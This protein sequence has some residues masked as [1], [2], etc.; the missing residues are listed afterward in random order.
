MNMV[1]PFDFRCE[2]VPSL[3]SLSNHKSQNKLPRP[4]SQTQP[5]QSKWVFASLFC[6]QPF[7][8]LEYYLSSMSRRVWLIIVFWLCAAEVHCRRKPYSRR[9]TGRSRMGR[10]RMP[11][12]ARRPKVA[13]PQKLKIFEYKDVTSGATFSA[14][15][16][17]GF[18]NATGTA[19]AEYFACPENDYLCSFLKRPQPTA[20]SNQDAQ[21]SNGG[22]FAV[23]SNR[24]SGGDVAVASG[25]ARVAVSNRIAKTDN[26]VVNYRRELYR[27]PYEKP[28]SQYRPYKPYPYYS[29]QS[30]YPYHKPKFLTKKIIIVKPPVDPPMESPPGPNP[31]GPG[32]G[33][34]PPNGVM[35]P[36]PPI[37]M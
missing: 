28:R 18:A 35:F 2:T 11:G 37:Y 1:F 10:S 36:P 31:G 12:V 27:Y 29:Y 22:G 34:P 14:D 32:V 5:A 9:S 26:R 24:A 17:S 25:D 33:P 19:A 13:T 7:E 16:N 6:L 3:S 20:V 8:Y 30:Q 21:F 4:T 15:F 23:S